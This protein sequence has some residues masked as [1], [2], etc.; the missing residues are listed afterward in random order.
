[1]AVVK[2]L[3]IDGAIVRIHDDYIRSREESIEILQRVAD[4]TLIA[5]NAQYNAKRYKEDQEREEAEKHEL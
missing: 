5:L 4:R 1:M 2:T 3:N